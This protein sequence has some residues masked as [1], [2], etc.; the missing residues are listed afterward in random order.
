MTLRNTGRKKVRP[1]P[2]FTPGDTVR[3]LPFEELPERH[4][5]AGHVRKIQDNMY[6]MALLDTTMTIERV[7]FSEV[8]GE[9]KFFMKE[10]HSDW[11]WL[12]DMFACNHIPKKE[13]FH[14]APQMPLI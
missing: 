5:Q 6:K 8:M 13:K 7:A 9:W 14:T 3:L 1:R 12:E 10:D 4:K 11:I 2:K